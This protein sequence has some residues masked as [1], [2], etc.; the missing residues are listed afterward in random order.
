MEYCCHIWAGDPVAT[1]DLLEKLQKQICRIFGPSLGASLE[2]VNPCESCEVFSIGIPL[3]D[4]L[5]NWF[6]WL[7]FLFLKGGLLFIL[8]DCMIFLP[9]FL[10]VK[11]MSMS[12]VSFLTQLDSK[13]IGL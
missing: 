3:V 7:R 11:R 12:T 6:N 4:V 13:I 9:P 8:T 1:L 2:P 5:Q 10:D